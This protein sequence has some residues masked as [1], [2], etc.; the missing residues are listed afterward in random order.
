M[1]TSSHISLDIGAHE[2]RRDEEEF[3]I[4]W[5]AELLQLLQNKFMPEMQWIIQYTHTGKFKPQIILGFH[6]DH[7]T[8]ERLNGRESDKRIILLNVWWRFY[9]LKDPSTD[10]WLFDFIERIKWTLSFM[11]EWENSPSRCT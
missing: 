6:H 11:T 9:G 10:F 1:H 4:D 8:A 3:I 7:N 5:L 2:G